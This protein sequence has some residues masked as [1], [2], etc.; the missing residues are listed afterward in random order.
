MQLI[1]SL[2]LL[3]LACKQPTPEVA[4]DK[5]A[6]APLSY[7]KASYGRQFAFLIE[8]VHASRWHIAYGFSST[9]CKH[10][11][12]LKHMQNT[13]SAA[14][15]L[16]IAPLAKMSAQPFVD[17][18]SYYERRAVAV[19]HYSLQL[20]L[21]SLQPHVQII[22]Y[23]REKASYAMSNPA[24]TIGKINPTSPTIPDVHL[25]YHKARHDYIG[26]T[27]FSMTVLVHEL[28]HAFGMLDTYP[29]EQHNHIGQ[30]A[31]I[32][33]SNS[34]YNKS[35][36]IKLATD[37][38]KGIKWL[39]R[40]Y[41]QKNEQIEDES[42]KCFFPDYELIE[43]EQRGAPVCLPRY[44]LITALKMAQQHE[45]QGNF[46]ATSKHLF[47]AKRMLTY[48]YGDPGKINAQDADGNTALH[49]AIINAQTSKRIHKVATTSAWL[50]NMP[51]RWANIGST[52]LAL[53]QCTVSGD[54]RRT[55]DKRCFDSQ[56]LNCACIDLTVKNK[57]QKT[58][59]EL[60]DAESAAAF[61]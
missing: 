21:G 59:R 50:P 12:P 14:L 37:D 28:G 25:A 54:A 38:I 45:Q 60:A 47:N 10:S 41:H 46:S 51:G 24:F 52:L 17:K 35:G 15:R 20:V 55:R 39:Y 33:A 53:P 2:L 27:R 56:D 48:N 3:L 8:H 40:Y 44:P 16:W 49:Y 31:S 30:P 5:F 57:Q 42:N 4:E 58:A 29:T 34:F 22:F 7:N 11:L 1:F 23:C 26:S 13:I 61:P 9:H 36:A 19:D 32:M 18:F 6:T 43:R